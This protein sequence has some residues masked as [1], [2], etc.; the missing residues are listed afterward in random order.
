MAARDHKGRPYAVM[1]WDGRPPSVEA[2]APGR[3]LLPPIGAFTVAA[4]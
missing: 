4:L 1:R 2:D 3:P